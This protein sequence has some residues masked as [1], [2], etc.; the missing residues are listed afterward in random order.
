MQQ[1]S[2]S[3][4][5]NIAHL[6]PYGAWIREKKRR[7]KNRGE[8]EI[9]REGDREVEIGREGGRGCVIYMNE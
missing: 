9:G 3:R 7:G 6:L 1:L 4:F 5:W 8:V 2:L